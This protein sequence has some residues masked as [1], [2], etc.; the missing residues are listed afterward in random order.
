MP[1]IPT[2]TSQKYKTE[3]VNAQT[4]KTVPTTYDLENQFVSRF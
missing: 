3:K 1:T 4:I 2:V